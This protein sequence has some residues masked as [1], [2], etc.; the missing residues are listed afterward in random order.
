MKSC[1]RSIFF[2]TIQALNLA[3]KGRIALFVSGSRLLFFTGH[4]S[5]YGYIVVF[6]AVHCKQP[7]ALFDPVLCEIMAAWARNLKWDLSACVYLCLRR[8]VNEPA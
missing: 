4:V 3:T 1:S 7:L 6:K 2:H 8:K 5:G